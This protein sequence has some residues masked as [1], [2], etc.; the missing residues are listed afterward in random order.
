M[1]DI[2]VVA[3]H[4]DD[5][6]LGCGATIAKHARLGDTVRVMLIADGVNSRTA[7]DDDLGQRQYAA[8]E[9]MQRLGVSEP[10]FHN[11]PDNRL[12]SV[13]LLDVVKVVEQ[14]ICDV[15]PKRIYTHYAYDLNVDHRVVCEAVHTATRPL[16]DQ[17][18]VEILCFE[19]MSSTE[20]NFH[21]DC[22]F[23]PNYF[24]DIEADFETKIAALGAYDMEMRDFPHPRS[25]EAIEALAKWRGASAGMVKAEGFILSRAL[26]YGDAV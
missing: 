10:I 1:N 20:W 21:S 25:L 7:T 17:T 16:A 19:V 13:D 9:A 3:A 22:P 23:K 11:F 4:A 12:D 24:V 18:T 2:L 15:K 14:V 6:V 8:K 26:R 5:E